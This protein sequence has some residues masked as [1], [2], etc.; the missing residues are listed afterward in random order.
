M[1]QEVK[2]SIPLRKSFVA[3][4]ERAKDLFQRSQPYTWKQKAVS[5]FLCHRIEADGQVSA[6]DQVRLLRVQFRE[7]EKQLN[8][9]GYDLLGEDGLELNGDAGPV[10][11]R[12][13]EEFEQSLVAQRESELEKFDNALLELL[14]AQTAEEAKGIVEKLL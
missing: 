5:D 12:A 6:F 8:S 1:K 13:V 10:L 11:K 7:S 3:V 2:L 9:L 14:A 4:V